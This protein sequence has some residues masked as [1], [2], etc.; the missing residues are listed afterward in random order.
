MLIDAVNKSANKPVTI[1][2]IGGKGGGGA[3]LTPHGKDLIKA[4]DT[5]NKNCWKF[6]DKQANKI[7]CI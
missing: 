2:R 4:F 6:L 5:I 3:R 7:N 1:T